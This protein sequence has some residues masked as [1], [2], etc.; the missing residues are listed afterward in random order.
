MDEYRN[1]AQ[2]QSRFL[3]QSLPSLASCQ[4]R[5]RIRIKTGH[6]TTNLSN[7]L[8]AALALRSFSSGLGDNVS[9]LYLGTPSDILVGLATPDDYPATVLGF[10]THGANN[11]IFTSEGY[12]MVSAHEYGHVLGLTEEY[13]YEPGALLTSCNSAPNALS[14][15]AGCNASSVVGVNAPWPIA[16]NTTAPG[17]ENACCYGYQNPAIW[18]ILPGGY[19]CH[20]FDDKGNNTKPGA[21]CCLG[22]VN[23]YGGRS[24]MG[25]GGGSEYGVRYHDAPS[26]AHIAT[27]LRCPT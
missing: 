1:E 18:G 5:I 15:A 16:F 2:A 17:H 22:N 3:I 9:S 25:F 6:F 23:Q 12:A 10:M 11:V 20:D 24:I 19:F 8:E 4:D 26:L 27:I 7:S 13:C 14:Y 21:V